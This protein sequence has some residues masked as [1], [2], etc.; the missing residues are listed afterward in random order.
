[1]DQGRRPQEWPRS[2]TSVKGIEPHFSLPD[3]LVGQ[4]KYI[5]QV[6]KTVLWHKNK[7]LL[8]HVSLTASCLCFET[9]RWWNLEANFW[10]ILDQL[11]TEKKNSVL[12]V[13]WP[14]CLFRSTTC[15][16]TILSFGF[17]VAH[18]VAHRVSYHH[19]MYRN[20]GRELRTRCVSQLGQNRSKPQSGHWFGQAVMSNSSKY[21]QQEWSPAWFVS[22]W[23]WVCGRWW[24][25]VSNLDKWVANTSFRLTHSSIRGAAH[26]A[27][28][29]S[30]DR[31][32]IAQVMKCWLQKILIEP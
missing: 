10:L 19:H 31:R 12:C 23:T 21:L 18:R 27:P 13:A 3:A 24:T 16:W 4:R 15:F 22:N 5:F 1:M 28:Q 25:T 11:G 6:W 17:A 2:M 32:R 20:L 29:I 26:I 8:L 14:V 7:Q 30:P 9:T